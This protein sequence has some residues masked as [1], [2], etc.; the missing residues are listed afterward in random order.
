MGLMLSGADCKGISPK[1]RQIKDTMYKIYH[2]NFGWSIWTKFELDRPLLQ[3]FRRL[4]Q[5]SFPA[6]PQQF[7]MNEFLAGGVVTLQMF[8]HWCFLS[9]C[10]KSQVKRIEAELNSLS[11]LKTN[12]VMQKLTISINNVNKKMIF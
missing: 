7:T 8:F 6:V 12:N 3:L 10:V 5:R 2:L 1:S 9:V 4:N 11:S